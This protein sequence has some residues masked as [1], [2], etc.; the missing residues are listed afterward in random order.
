[1]ALR[2]LL[3]R[4]KIQEQKK[5]LDEKRNEEKQI[6]TRSGELERA[7]EE[8]DDNTSEEDKKQ[9]EDE[10]EQLEKDKEALETA[11]K[12]IEDKIKELEDD[13]KKEQEK[14]PSGGTSGSDGSGERS[15]GG[16]IMY[17]GKFFGMSIEERTQFFADEKV[18][19]FLSEVREAI[20]H[21]RSIENLDL[22][23]PDNMLPLIRQVTESNSKL[24]GKVTLQRIPGT[25][26]QNIMGE[27]PEAFWD[28]MCAV[29]K[30][31]TLVFN[32]IEVDGYKVSGY[33]A[34][35]NA[36][37][38]DS[39]LNLATELI[40]A[41]GQA[42]A[43]ALDKAI[44]YGKGVKMPMGIVTSLLKTTAP[45]TYPEKGRTWTDLSKS[46]VKSGTA[47]LSGLKLFQEI[48]E[49]SGL[50]DNDYDTSEVTWL[51]NKKSHVKLLSE[52]LGANANAALVAGMNN[53]MPV[54]GGEIIEF[55]Y[56]PDDTIIFGYLKNYLLVE[57]AG[58]KVAQSE[59]VR[60]IEDQTVFKGTARYDGQPVIREAFG[61]YGIG[62]A[63]TTTSPLFAGEEE[64]EDLAA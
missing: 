32:S 20:K 57:R 15:E 24:I 16:T 46:N 40:T 13:L 47:S 26:R 52:S 4:K 8:I 54:V 9:V 37:L 17:R 62:G 6:E 27:I 56:I 10:V 60:F 33:F 45:D 7:I 30:E 14:E 44:I 11:K 12:L 23:I 28:E 35:C 64:E 18:R 43:K 53:Q 61:I 41:L 59:H 2:A 38:E 55:K 1:M 42:I 3:L 19:S 39:D 29:L 58:Q 34:V 21:K 49:T 31:M 5:L 36:S 22:T 50:V 48:I 25:G 51:M 63:P